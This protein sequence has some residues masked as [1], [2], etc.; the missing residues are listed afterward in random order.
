MF[1]SSIYYLSTPY[2]PFIGCSGVWSN[3]WESLSGFSFCRVLSVDVAR[4]VPLEEEG[5]FF[6]NP[7]VLWFLAASLIT[8]VHGGQQYLTISSF[9]CT[10]DLPH[11]HPLGGYLCWMSHQH[12]QCL[13]SVMY[14]SQQ[15]L[16]V[17]SCW[18]FPHKIPPHEWLSFNNLGPRGY[19][20][21]KFC[22]YGTQATSFSTS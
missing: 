21:S 15:L 4:A 22:W 10:V 11:H 14:G 9:L 13:P 17:T 19:I 7:G 16:S 8:A 3:W 18:S 6:H 2:L 20:S 1:H 12:L 5:T